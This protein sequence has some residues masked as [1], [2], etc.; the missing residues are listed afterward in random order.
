MDD[1]EKFGGEA[2]VT[3]KGLKTNPK[4]TPVLCEA[5]GAVARIR[6]N[7]P[8]RLNAMDSKTRIRTGALL[9]FRRNGGRCALDFRLF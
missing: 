5:D 6:L 4:E 3:L 2:A 7:R 8:D 1:A 9:R